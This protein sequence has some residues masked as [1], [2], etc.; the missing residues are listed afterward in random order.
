MPPHA[1]ARFVSALASAM[2]S[3]IFQMVDVNSSSWDANN[4]SGEL[5][6]IPRLHTELQICI[7]FNRMKYIIYIPLISLVILSQ[8]SARSHFK[9]VFIVHILRL[10]T[11]SIVLY[12]SKMPSCLSFKTQG[13]GDWILSPSY[14]K[15][16]NK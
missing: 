7:Q 8:N 2:F 13:F 4:K 14:L 9:H 10:W 16:P 12:L 3:H 6:V 5:I 15:C 11:S 1:A